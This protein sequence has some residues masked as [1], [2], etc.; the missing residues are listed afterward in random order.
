MAEQQRP[1]AEKQEAGDSLG[2]SPVVACVAN[3]SE[4]RRKYVLDSLA[5]V[6]SAVPGV[7]LLDREAD[8]DHNRSVF[9]FAGGPGAVAEAAIASVGKAVALIDL[10]EHEG[11]HPRIGAAD[12]VPFVPMR[13]FT[14]VECGWMAKDVGAEIWR[15]FAVP[16]YLY[17]AA[18]RFPHRRNLAHVRRGNF[19]GLRE[20]I[21]EDPMRHPDFGEA[22]LHPTAGATCVGARKILIAWNVYLDTA[23][24]AVAT[25]IA[26]RIRAANG[27]LA[28]VKALGFYIAHR[29]QA[30]VS[31]NLVDYTVMPPHMVLQEIHRLAEVYGTRVTSSELI[32]L[33]PKAALQ[34]AEAAGVDLLLEEVRLLPYV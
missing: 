8:P 22:R 28:C 11:C 4:G 34:A 21:A 12:V 16:V 13:R 17:E 15:Q 32:G 29:K 7:T 24:V 23:D 33:M 2:D 25:A 14:V 31:M 9:T 10:N 30:Q 27:G 3:Y 6:I 5:E 20:V 1:Q 18:A 19:E 26:G